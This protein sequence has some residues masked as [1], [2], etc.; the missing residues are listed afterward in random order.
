MSRWNKDPIREAEEFE[1]HLRELSEMPAWMKKR[2]AQ[3]I[4]AREKDF[5]RRHRDMNAQIDQDRAVKQGVKIQTPT[6]VAEKT[7]RI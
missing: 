7:R 2:E 4:N 5:E 3:K 1:K 6:F